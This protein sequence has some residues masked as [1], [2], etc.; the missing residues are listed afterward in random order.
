[1][2]E[3]RLWEI[4]WL[5]EGNKPVGDKVRVQVFCCQVLC[6]SSAHDVTFGNQVS[7]FLQGGYICWCSQY[8]HVESFGLLVIFLLWQWP[9]PLVAWVKKWHFNSLIYISEKHFFLQGDIWAISWL[10]FAKCPRK[11]IS[12]KGTW[13]QQS[14]L[15]TEGKALIIN[16]RSLPRYSTEWL[17]ELLGRNE[18]SPW[19]YLWRKKRHKKRPTSCSEQ[20]QHLSKSPVEKNNLLFLFSYDSFLLRCIKPF[21]H[22][23]GDRFRLGWGTSIC[24]SISST[25]FTE[26][27][28]WARL[29]ATVLG[30]SWAAGC[31]ATPGAPVIHWGELGWDSHPHTPG[32]SGPCWRPGCLQKEKEQYLE[33]WLQV[34][35]KIT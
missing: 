17:T 27:G 3:R 16:K 23:Q 25:I 10:T 29:K 35:S 9:V 20:S 33:S 24:N 31:T 22:L 15:E 5:A 6:P 26:Y 2:K 12:L 18:E 21:Q 11:L 8:K 13:L 14:H 32:Q 30:A 19:S 34:R 7:L 1:M 4:M 28:W